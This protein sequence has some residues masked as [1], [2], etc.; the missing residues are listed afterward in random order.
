MQYEYFDCYDEVNK[1]MRNVRVE[2]NKRRKLVS[3]VGHAR[4][5]FVVFVLLK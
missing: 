2:P 1:D 3:R 5:D 4:G